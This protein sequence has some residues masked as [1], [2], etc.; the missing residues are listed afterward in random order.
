MEMG[1]KKLQ[2]SMSVVKRRNYVANGRGHEPHDSTA[3]KFYSDFFLRRSSNN[4]QGSV[5]YS[6]VVEKAF[7]RTHEPFHYYLL[8]Q[9]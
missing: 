6:F 1:H 3:G 5:L 2:K 9:I 7:K 4:W 8:Y